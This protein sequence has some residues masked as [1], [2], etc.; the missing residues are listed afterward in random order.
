LVRARSLGNIVLLVVAAVLAIVIATRSDEE[1]R[2]ELEPL[3][4]ENPRSVSHIRLEPGAARIIELRRTDGAWHLL[5]PLRI[6]ANDFRI[7]G[8]VRV[9]EAPVHARIDADPQQLGRFGLKS[10]Q[11]RIVF[12]GRE[13]LFGDTEPIHG[14]RYLLFDGKVVLVDDSF[15]SHLSAS[16]ANYVNTALL[17]HDPHLQRIDL[18]GMRIYWQAGDWRVDGGQGNVH[19]EGI[20]NL[21]K[22][23]RNAQA[24]AVRPYEPSLDWNG[25]VRVELAD[26]PVQF[27]L[28]RT[29]YEMILGRADLAIQYHLTKS[30][31][32]RLLGLVPALEGRTSLQERGQQP[33]SKP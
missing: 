29:E 19:A 11:A 25:I 7:N 16:A 18:P 31:G 1:E 8:L 23:W 12:D 32:A 24:T 27:D 21:V 6:A 17:G 28:A 4:H 2:I 3:S 9:L 10:P 30:A 33:Q 13:V 14:R 20:K 22:S 15:F 5:E 26:G